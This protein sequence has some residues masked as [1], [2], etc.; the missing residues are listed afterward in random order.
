MSRQKIN[1]GTKPNDKSG[2]PLRT[3]MVK[4]NEMTEEI[5][6]EFPERYLQEANN[7][8]DLDDKETA[9]ANLKVYSKQQADARYYT[10]QQLSNGQLDGRYYTKQKLNEGALDDRYV[11]PNTTPRFGQVLLSNPASKADHAVR[12]ATMIK[13]NSPLKG[14]GRILDGVDLK[15][16]YNTRNLK[17]S[18]GTLNTAQNIDEDAKML[19]KALVLK[20]GLTIDE[21]LGYLKSADLTGFSWLK[22]GF[23]LKKDGDDWS[24]VIDNL[25]VRKT[26]MFR[27]LII[28]QLA[29]MGGS[30]LLSPARGKIKSVNGN[31]VT[32]ED[33]NNIGVSQFRKDDLFVAREVD[34]DGSEALFVAGI[35]KAVDGMTLTLSNEL[36]DLPVADAKAY[37]EN[38]VPQAD[39]YWPLDGNLADIFAGYDFT[40]VGNP[41]FVDGIAGKGMNFDGVDD[42]ATVEAYD[43]LSGVK[44]HTFA[45]WVNPETKSGQ[46][47]FYQY[48]THGA[49]YTTS[50]MILENGTL[51]FGARSGDSDN[52]QTIN[53]PFTY[54]EE[55]VFV[56]GVTDIENG[57]LLLYINGELEKSSSV[58][59][60]YDSIQP[61]NRD[62]AIAS[63]T[64]YG[65]RFFEGKEDDIRIYKRA[66]SPREVQR[67]YSA[68]SKYGKISDLSKGNVIVQRGNASDPDRQGGISATAEGPYS[69]MYDGVDSLSKFGEPETIKSF[70]GNTEGRIFPDFPEL[71]G[72]QGREFASVI[73]SGY[74]SG[75]IHSRSAYIGGENTAGYA[76]MGD[77]TKESGQYIEFEDGKI[78]LGP[79]V[80]FGYENITGEK[81]PKWFFGDGPPEE[82]STDLSNAQAGDLYLDNTSGKYYKF[83]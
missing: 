19:L 60:G 9:R 42:Y 27:E 82:T 77:F 4:V 53:V 58:S 10:R 44:Q 32:L 40:K 16:Q 70:R 73:Q 47:T 25:T 69:L 34:V 45:L 20:K 38:D 54:T 46:N 66:L 13:T 72:S 59:F 50:H 79:N 18:S 51:S 74:H 11:R 43:L 15:L 21:A 57:E 64:I 55:W 1:I 56:V 22:K 49:V 6:N 78:K 33:P 12:A 80:T 52:Q 62:L 37:L 36:W 7:L 61:D 75:A 65:E 31:K 5:Y 30:T 26:A 24:Q 8:S 63:R 41:Q 23:G 3:A 29:A 28:N 67:L 2:D 76:L 71:D 81:P 35:V 39:S 68:T 83:D 14:G 48:G 17:A